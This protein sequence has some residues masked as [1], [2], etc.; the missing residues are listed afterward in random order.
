MVRVQRLEAD[1]LFDRGC[2]VVDLRH[3]GSSKTRFLTQTVELW[4]ELQ[5]GSQLKKL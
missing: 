3:S 4:G 2:A 1:A 5:S